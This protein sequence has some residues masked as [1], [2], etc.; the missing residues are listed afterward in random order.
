LTDKQRAFV[1]EYLIDFNGTQA[2]IRAG[3]SER[4]AKQIAAEN[5]SK[6]DLSRAIAEA[7]EARSRR[8]KVD[9]DYVLGLLTQTAERC[10]KGNVKMVFDPVEK[11]MVPA[12]DEEGRIVWEFDSSGANRAA[13]LIGKHLKMFTDK[14]DHTTGGQ[15]FKALVG[16]DLDAI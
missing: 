12:T 10:I 2:A 15:P 14:V 9:Q 11:E 5:L 1:D 13:E 7:I 16:V 6:P 8:C 4:T 3:Y